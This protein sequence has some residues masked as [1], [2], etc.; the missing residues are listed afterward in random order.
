M[1][2]INKETFSVQLMVNRDSFLKDIK[3]RIAKYY[4]PILADLVVKMVQPD[5]RESIHSY[6]N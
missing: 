4:S 1:I 2:L 5:P 6:I 3:E